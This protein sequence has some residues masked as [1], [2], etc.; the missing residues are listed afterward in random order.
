M[1][2][3]LPNDHEDSRRVRAS[4]PA[5][6]CARQPKKCLTLDDLSTIYEATRIVTTR[7]YM[8]GNVGVSELEVLRCKLAACLLREVK[9]RSLTEQELLLFV[10]AAVSEL[11]RPYLKQGEA[12]QPTSQAVPALRTAR[13]SMPD[14]LHEVFDL[15]ATSTPDEI[16]VIIARAPCF[17]EKQ[18][19]EIRRHCKALGVAQHLP[20]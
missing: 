19:R 11:A 17:V 14:D 3:T 15:L 9:S 10:V 12:R 7:I 8:T 6:R 1:P 13:Q 4:R 20:Y 16:A 2:R 5:R 18:I